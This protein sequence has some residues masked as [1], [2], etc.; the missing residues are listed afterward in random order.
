MTAPRPSWQRLLLATLLALFA[1][2]LGATLSSLLPEAWR[3]GVPTGMGYLA[4]MSYLITAGCMALGGALAGH[5]F[6]IIAVGLS[7]ALWTSTLVM[8]A[9]VGGLQPDGA[10]PLSQVLRGNALNMLLSVAAATLGTL[11]GARWRDQ[12]QARS[13]PAS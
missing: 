2:L 1:L 6:V 10:S 7:V 11:A 4:P 13:A 8:L 3:R 9:G 5:R 12:R